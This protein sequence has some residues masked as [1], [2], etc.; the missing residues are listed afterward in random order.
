MRKI[1][2]FRA[3]GG[4]II[5]VSHDMNAVKTL[6]DSAILLDH[7]QVIE[8]GSPKDI[9]DTYTNNLLM[10]LHQGETELQKSSSIDEF[11]TKKE[12]I[13]TGDLKL[14]SLKILNATDQ[15]ISSIISGELIKIV[16][17]IASER[18]LEDPHYGFII[19]NNLGLSIYESNTL[20]LGVK[21][22]TLSKDHPAKVT[23]SWK[24]P[25]FPGDYSISL[26][27]ANDGYNKNSFKEYL[28]N[29]Y[30]IKIIKILRKECHQTYSGIIDMKPDITVD[31][32][33][34]N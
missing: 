7:G 1:Q 31:C 17:E 5:F 34:L 24:V 27:V 11:S 19:R 26:G 22:H 9:V 15:E 4:S 33:N 21:T 2:E 8:S 16:F 20:L 32:L 6:C 14:L 25:L 18:D 28:L 10:K 23:I 30:D 12:K 29:T 13:S 3:S